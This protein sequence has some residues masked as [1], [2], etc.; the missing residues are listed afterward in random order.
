MNWMKLANLSILAN[1]GS[2][3]SSC[4]ITKWTR[5]SYFGGKMLLPWFIVYFTTDYMVQNQIIEKYSMTLITLDHFSASELLLHS[6]LCLECMASSTQAFFCM[7]S[8]WH[9]AW[10]MM[11]D[12]KKMELGNR[13]AQRN[14][15]QRTKTSN[16]TWKLPDNASRLW[17]NSSSLVINASEAEVIPWLGCLVNKMMLH[18]TSWWLH[19]MFLKRIPKPHSQEL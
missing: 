7:Q 17:R 10:G 9:D 4:E 18:L 11:H 19:G 6:N 1:T 12:I 3:D 8:L 16:Y 5:Y 15:L 14:V 13:I 2:I